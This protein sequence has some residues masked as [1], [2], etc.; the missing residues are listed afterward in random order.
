MHPVRDVGDLYLVARRRI[1]YVESLLP[2]TRVPVSRE[3]D[4]AVAFA[5]I[6]LLNCWAGFSRSLYFSAC[7]GSRDVR[8]G[9]ILTT[10]S[11]R[12]VLD[13][14]LFAAQRFT[15]RRLQRGAVTHRDEPNWLQPSTLITLLDDIGATNLGTVT[16]AL[17]GKSRVLTD[18]PSVRNFFG[19][20]GQDTARKAAAVG[21][22]YGMPGHLHPAE[23]CVSFAPGRPQSIIRDWAADLREITKLAVA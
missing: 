17:A 9:R 12:D 6:E 10:L 3:V 4:R 20:R 1:A 5:T 15:R 21:R 22:N 11:L 8:G 23:L 7:F 18:L 13:A 2:S 14:Q 16:T 19:H